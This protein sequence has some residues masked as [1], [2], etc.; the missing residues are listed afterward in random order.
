MHDESAKSLGTLPWYTRP[1]ASVVFSRDLEK[2]RTSDRANVISKEQKAKKRGTGTGVQVTWLLLLKE[3]HTLYTSY[4]PDQCRLCKL[5]LN[6]IDSNPD[7]GSGRDRKNTGISMRYE[8]ANYSCR[9]PAIVYHRWNWEFM[10]SSLVRP[11]AQS[12]LGGTCVSFHRSFQC[13]LS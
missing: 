7:T 6:P 12:S 4:W 1:R 9:D 10:P 5:V 8:P 3:L 2:G 11:L 13:R